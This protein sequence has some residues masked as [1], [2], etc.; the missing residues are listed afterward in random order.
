VE[1]ASAVGASDLERRLTE[2]P[3]WQQLYE[4]LGERVFRF[5]YRMT[6]SIELAEDL[7]H[8]T[9]VR[10]HQRRGQYQGRGSVR[11]WVFQVAVNQVR[12][13]M[14]HR[15][16]RLIHDAGADPARQYVAG[17]EERLSVERALAQLPETQRLVVLLHDVDGYKHHEIAEMLEIA[18]G[19]SKARLSRAREILRGLLSRRSEPGPR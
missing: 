1:R 15:R 7:T 10:V 8:D 11:G 6:R 18:E 5:I 4:G 13:H 12:D 16:L 2:L 19:T 17:Q 3:P 9:F 14:R